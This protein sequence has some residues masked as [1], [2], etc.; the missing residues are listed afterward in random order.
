MSAEH[1][2]HAPV[3][4]LIAE[5]SENAA[6][7]FDSLLRDAGIATRMEIVDLPMALDKLSHADMMLCN[8]ALPEL[9]QLLPRLTG[10]APQVPVIVVNNDDASLTQSEGME[11]GAVDVVSDA[12]S[13]H[14]VLVV[15][16]EL[17]HVCQNIQL[18][19]VRKALEEAEQRCQLLLQSSRA[20]IAYVH[21]G[22]HIFANQGYL[23]LFGFDAVDDLEGLPLIDL[24]DGDSIQTLKDRLKQFRRDSKES[25]FDFVGHSQAGVEVTGNM[26]LAAA[27]YEG[28]ECVQVT[29]R[30]SASAE[31][32]EL[33]TTA[34][35]EVPILLDTNAG[36]EET[37]SDDVPVLDDAEATV[38]GAAATDET[39][40]ASS[41][42][43]DESPFTLELE[44]ADSSRS[45]DAAA[46]AN[47]APE[48]PELVIDFDTGE[49]E[50]A[51]P[52][53]I[54]TPEPA[55][56][57]ADEQLAL[58]TNGSEAL[59]DDIDLVDTPEDA[60]AAAGDA[61]TA[62]DAAA[63]RK[64][65]NGPGDFLKLSEAA[66]EAADGQFVSIF[67]AQI[68]GYEDMQRSFGLAGAEDACRMVEA[69][70]LEEASGPLVKISPF[71]WAILVCDKTREDAMDQVDGYR[72]AVEG[73]MFE[74]R[75]KTVRPTCTF[76][77]SILNPEGSDSMAAA[78]EAT[79]NNAFTTLRTTLESSKGNSVELPSFE[80]AEQEN[81]DEAN[82]ILSL[83][84]EAIEN[85]SFTLLFQPI[86]SLRGDSDEHYEVFLRM[87]DRNGELMVPGQFL[88]TAI[89]NGVAGKIDRWVI[90]QSIKMLSAHR[91]NGH[92]TRL[93]INLTCNSVADPEFIQW[94]GVAIKAARLP[95][96]A[97]IFQVT[98][99]DAATYIRQTR[100]F[101]EGLRNLHCRSSLSRFGLHAEPLE[102]L[103]HIPVDFVKLDGS[104]VE[105][106]E[107]NPEEKERVKDMVIELQNQG[108]LTIVP[109]VESASLL[110]TLWQA[111][112]NYIQG[113]Y[114]QEPSTSM[115]YDFSTD[116]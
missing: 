13:R 95:S 51:A 105:S 3:R 90:L 32:A 16:R 40:E 113:H 28:E 94:L 63:A 101:A 31:A 104:L 65:A 100:E 77:G 79:L 8:A 99:Q 102:L 2:Q 59:P 86:I 39:A 81:D 38:N 76:A 58:E 85:H 11:L 115:D 54:E 64:P 1:N 43:G 82:R 35:E 24:L 112:V 5:R 83:I 23:K 106:V 18:K 10:M 87:S 114:L 30:T 27:E 50:A 107:K 97:V 69:R 7:Q 78:L 110:S 98:E 26:T 116:D 80:S 4:L 67:A 84:S 88:Q 14:L 60:D 37:A 111:G 45:E 73:M 75:E 108:K 12:E 25:D 62:S 61:E 72:A 48:P 55:E 21:E 15:K 19:Q 42:D 53:D 36:A 20:A 56:G 66:V 71:Q 68:D 92:N 49:K 6:H 47:E 93:T 89:D 52:Q 34:E 74:V 33:A 22:M 41:G 103:G 96:D 91:A 46:E 57:S 9:H 29:V 44:A 17:E 70:L 109:M